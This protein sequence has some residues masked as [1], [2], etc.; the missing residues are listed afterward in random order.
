MRTG[1]R[2]AGAGAGIM[3][4]ARRRAPP[5]SLH[6]RPLAAP[7]R[8]TQERKQHT[9][10]AKKVRIPMPVRVAIKAARTGF[11]SCPRQRRAALPAP[12]LGCAWTAMGRRATVG[13]SRPITAVKLSAAAQGRGDAVGECALTQWQ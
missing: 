12:G 2:A 10:A 1:E 5:D 8:I 6:Q 9:R 13:P 4:Q 7:G 11:G 3:I